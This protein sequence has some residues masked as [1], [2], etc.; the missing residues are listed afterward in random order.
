ME[1]IKITISDED[2]SIQLSL[3]LPEAYRPLVHI[4]Q[5]GT[6]KETLTTKEV[7][8]SA[9]SVM[10]LEIH[11]ALRDIYHPLVSFKSISFSFIP[12]SE[13]VRAD[14]MAK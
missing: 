8:T 7:I 1:S 10:K 14:T 12:R 13:N 3:G 4:L 6:G 11:E 9:Y 2:Q 5:Y